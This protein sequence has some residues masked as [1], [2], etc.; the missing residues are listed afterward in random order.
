[1]DRPL[2]II[3][4]A[5]KITHTMI[6]YLQVLKDKTHLSCGY[7]LAGMPYFKANLIKLA[8]KQREG[9][10]E[11]L[12]RINIWHELEGLSRDEVKFICAKS[13]INDID[14]QREF[15]NKK[16]FGDLTNA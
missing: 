9:Y 11:F 7:V 8:N 10:G 6:L 15:I 4:E 1:M 3:D 13:G 14:Q 2:V 5:G 16:R 12:R